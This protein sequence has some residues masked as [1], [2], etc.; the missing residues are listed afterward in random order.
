MVVNRVPSVP[1]GNVAGIHI[2]HEDAVA[3]EKPEDRLD[4][5]PARTELLLFL[6]APIGHDFFGEVGRLV[7]IGAGEI[8]DKRASH[9]RHF[10]DPKFVIVAE[11]FGDGAT[12]DVRH[13]VFSETQIDIAFGAVVLRALMRFDGGNLLFRLAFHDKYATMNSRTEGVAEEQPLPFAVLLR[14][15]PKL[16]SIA[17]E[18]TGIP[19]RR[20]AD[21]LAHERL[22]LAGRAA[23]P[24][25]PH[26]ENPDRSSSLRRRDH[27]VRGRRRKPLVRLPSQRHPSRATENGDFTSRR[28]WVHGLRTVVRHKRPKPADDT[29]YSFS[30]MGPR[31][32]NRG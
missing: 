32:E 21:S 13:V 24:G 25:V 2:G 22:P 23:R 5:R 29:N 27:P 14:S 15:V 11:H 18:R 4:F 19:F 3:F 30:S 10:D 31:S 7:E 6:R 12:P 8:E 1:E 17:H 9:D 16:R 28:Q 26:P 20:R